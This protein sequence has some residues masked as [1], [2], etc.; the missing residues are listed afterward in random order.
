MAPIS[1]ASRRDKTLSGLADSLRK[2]FAGQDKRISIPEIKE[3][4]L[5]VEDFVEPDYAEQ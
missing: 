3:P 1:C 4:V 2:G 5:Q